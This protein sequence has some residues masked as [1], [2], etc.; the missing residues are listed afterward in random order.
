M[1]TKT[2]RIFAEIECLY[3]KIKQLD[4]FSK[5]LTTL[6][7]PTAMTA[8]LLLPLSMR[9]LISTNFTGISQSGQ[10]K[11]QLHIHLRLLWSMPVGIQHLMIFFWTLKTFKHMRIKKQLYF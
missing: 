5:R 1:V 2:A 8:T 4:I 11:I 3:F 7:L 9:A 10:L 6:F